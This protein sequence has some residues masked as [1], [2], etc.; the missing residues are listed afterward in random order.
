[1]EGGGRQSTPQWAPTPTPGRQ[2]CYSM[3]ATL[4]RCP[5]KSSAPSG[6]VIRHKWAGGGQ[7]RGE[8]SYLFFSRPPLPAPQYVYCPV[9]IYWWRGECPSLGPTVRPGLCGLS[10]RQCS[11]CKVSCEAPRKPLPPVD[12]PGGGL[13]VPTRTPPSGRSEKHRTGRA[14]RTDR[15]TD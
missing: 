2:H 7:N 1:M 5:C 11:P 6:R 8:F 4:R 14:Q 9:T 12:P 3:F 10:H 15:P 13:L